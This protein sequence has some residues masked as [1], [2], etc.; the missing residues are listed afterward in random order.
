MGGQVYT[1]P[2]WHPPPGEKGFT[3]QTPDKT[4][5]I[6]GKQ[7]FDRAKKGLKKHYSEKLYFS[8]TP[9]KIHNF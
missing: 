6:T 8:R 5:R 2:G 3:Q 1:P 4:K 7:D 9:G